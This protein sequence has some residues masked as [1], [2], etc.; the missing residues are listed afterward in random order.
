[1]SG[2]IGGRRTKLLKKSSYN[3]VVNLNE[4]Q[5]LLVNT[6]SG[7]IDQVP[8]SYCSFIESPY[9]HEK[10]EITD[11]LTQR[12]YLID[13]EIDEGELL[14]RLYTEVQDVARTKIPIKC[15]LLVTFDCNLRCAYC[16][17]QHKI[18]KSSAM[19]QEK[20]DAIFE[21]L[22]K[23]AA[24]LNI[25]SDAT[26]IIQLF[27]GE[28]LL[29][30]NTALVEYILKKCKSRGY[31][32]QITTNGVYVPDFQDMLLRYGV[33]EIQITVDGTADFHNRRRVGSD[34]KSLMDSIGALLFHNETYI[35]LR[36]NVDRGNLNSL[37]ELANEIID[38]RW[39]TSSK[40]FAYT[41]PLRDPSFDSQTLIN[42]RKELLAAFLDMKREYP[43]TE[44]FWFMGWDGYQPVIGLEYNGR[45]PY[46][47]T[48]ICD[49]NIN[50][51]VFT[52]SGSIHLCA[53]E[54][55]GEAGAVGSYYPAFSLDEPKFSSIY[56]KT[57]QELGRCEGCVMLPVCGGG[58]DLMTGNEPFL[59][60]YC[61]SV[62]DCFAYGLA[63]YINHRGQ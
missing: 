6:L 61:R 19:T 20:V 39:Y 9:C 63:D 31:N 27:G 46:P 35:K 42:G 49:I 4:D 56:Y 32:V 24:N 10:N 23:L 29:P 51:F 58:C 12:R 8:A 55:Q 52:P 22:P 50:Q 30:E 37:P 41:T 33:N 11:F 28:P 21:T 36:V 18:N 26:P 44:I 16:W 62:R 13:S 53:E 15:V 2:G 59:E 34:Y 14:R 17:Q 47:K 57:P 7:A 25:E 5:N 45:F 48:Y 43:Q 40:F 3:L 54:S 38:R 1:M 60:A